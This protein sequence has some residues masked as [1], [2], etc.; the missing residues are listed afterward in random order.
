MLPHSYRGYGV[1]WLQHNATLSRFANGRCPKNI[2]NRSVQLAQGDLKLCQSYDA[3]R[4]PQ[5]QQSEITITKPPWAVSYLTTNFG[6]A[7]CKIYACF[8]WK[9]AL[10]MRSFRNLG[11]SR[12]GVTIFWR[13][14][15][16]HIIGWF[17][18]FWVIMHARFIYTFLGVPM[19][20]GTLQ[21]VVDVIYLRGIPH[22][23]KFN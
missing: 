14:P 16:R 2:N 15:K 17:H 11:D 9:T 1:I 7:Y 22:S 18:T 19:K 3:V 12:G 5:K 8:E 13:Y 21:K 4:F 23:T 10:V 20:K 6:G